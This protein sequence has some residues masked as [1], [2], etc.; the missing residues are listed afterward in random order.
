VAALELLIKAESIVEYT[1]VWWSV[2]PHLSFGTVE[3]RV[4]DSQPTA[5]ESDALAALIV[6]CVM[7]A[8][9]DEDEGRPCL[10]VPTGLVEENMWRAIRY[11]LD[12][13]MIDFD[14]RSQ[15]ESAE[16]LDRLL[17]WT[18]P[19]RAELGLSPV[20]PA[21][22]GAQRQRDALASGRTIRAV[23]GDL[24]RNTESTYAPGVVA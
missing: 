6:A 19:V 8:A 17:D 3:V 13:R 12:G 24:V 18:Q 4:C 7:Q 21:R 2:R 14:T 22:N 11:G 20:F 23:Y 1:Q 15:F 16:I 9:R 5:A 10:D